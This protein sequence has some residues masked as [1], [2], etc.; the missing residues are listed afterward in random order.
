M[1]S[2]ERIG[3][4]GGTFD[5]IHNTHIA[6][7]RA[8]LAQRRVSRVVFVVS[9]RPPHKHEGPYAAPEERYAMVA[10]AVAGQAGMAASRLELDRRG[11]SYTVD[12]LA[13]FARDCPGAAL[14]LILGMDSLIDL[15]TWRDPEGILARAHILVVPRP[16]TWDIPASLDGHYDVLDFEETTLSSTEIRERIAAGEPIDEL[17]PPGVGRLICERRIYG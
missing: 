7:A 3:V 4:F 11:P 10:A 1:G 13:A 16:G 15:P 2:P 14:A 9:A 5:P 17:V 6:V 8:A 12:T